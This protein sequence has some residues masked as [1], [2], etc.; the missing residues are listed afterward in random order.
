M[1]YREMWE[2]EVRHS[3]LNKY[4]H[5]RGSDRSVVE[6][7]ARAQEQAWNE[8]WEKKSAADLN[9][10]EKEAAIRSKEEKKEL[11]IAKT[12]EAKDAIKQIETLL[13]NTL[14]IN[15]AI[16]WKSLLDSKSFQQK[17]PTAPKFAQIPT[18]PDRSEAK[19]QPAIGFLEKLFSQL[20]A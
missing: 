18:E 16:D 15:D 17:K 11:A 20:R 13:L 4:R 3:G 9:K 12:I 6:Q 5:I 19:Y 2:I 1:A 14:A 8:M 7:K 10:R